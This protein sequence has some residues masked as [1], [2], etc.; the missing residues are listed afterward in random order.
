MA[1]RRYAGRLSGPLR[2]RVDIDLQVARV[3]AA[4]ATSGE[5]SGA[6]TADA[7]ARVEQARTIAAERWRGSPWRVNGEVP[8]ER[9]RQGPLR[10]PAAVR[11]PLDRALERGGV[12]LR[13]Y[14]RVLRIAWTL[15]DLAGL[16]SPGGDQL[17]HALFLKKGLL[18]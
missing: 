1:I 3:A 18:A 9:L 8:G 12:T 4:R 10:L 13:A 6:S 2:D 16:C 17:G 5:R 11:A 15:S 7:R 14:D